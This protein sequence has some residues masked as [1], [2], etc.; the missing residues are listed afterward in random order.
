MKKS[1]YIASLTL[2]ATLG[3]S[4]FA[5]PAFAEQQ[6]KTYALIV[7][8]NGSV[9]KDVKPLRY[10]DDDGARFY[11]MFKDYADDTRLLTTLD[12]ESQK[13]FPKVVG[14]TLP[15]T[16]KNLEAQVKDLAAQIAADKAKGI[17]A[18]VYLV[19]TGH[20]NVDKSGEGYLSLADGKLRRSDLLRD[21]IRPLDASYTH[22]IIDACHAYFMV[23]TRGDGWQD[24]RS[25]E[26]LDTQFHAFLSSGDAADTMP[27]VGMI[28]STAGAQE[29]HEWS[30]F[31][32]GVFSHQLRSGLLGAADADGDGRVSYTEIE[33]YLVAAN[34]SVT[35]PKAK[36]RVHVQAPMQDQSVSVATLGRFRN[37]TSLAL[38]GDMGRAWVEDSRGVRYADV[39]PAPGLNSELKL[40]NSPTPGQSFFVRTR[41]QQ[42]EVPTGTAVAMADLSW[43]P[44]SDQARG[45]VDEAF[46]EQLF[47]TPFG[48]AF[49]AGFTAARDNAPVSTVQVSNQSPWETVVST[50]YTLSTGLLDEGGLQ[51]QF[52]LGIGTQHANYF[53]VSGFAEYGL[54]LVD[55]YTGHRVAVG[56]QASYVRPLG[57]LE[58]GL[59]LRLGPQLV[60]IDR[61]ALAADPIG[62]RGS[63]S[64]VAGWRAEGFTVYGT[65]GTGLDVVTYAGVDANREDL[66]LN[67]F[68][69]LGLRF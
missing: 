5:Q 46:R 13:I 42:A 40:L 29:V 59:Q 50:D 23:K 35:N 32:A 61:D 36:I 30:Q 49:V 20:G 14:Q 9:D 62:L 6:T 8:N 39:H 69:G 33:A 26:T 11:E 24:D 31:G 55:T 2:A 21:L 60:L 17:R 22:V 34:A 54:S 48:P 25:G 10:A 37:T 4:T 58:L 19:F 66:L 45:A 38:N 63:A 56:A 7:A 47:A 3:M 67:P 1:T 68:A 44:L 57:G 52:S 53:G 15:P 51:H 27:T 12:A 65:V 43:Q 16:Q 41:D 18:E 28:L 64:A